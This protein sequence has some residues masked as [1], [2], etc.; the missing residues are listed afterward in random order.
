MRYPEMGAGLRPGVKFPPIEA[1]K[2]G[3]TNTLLQDT[4]IEGIQ[5][6]SIVRDGPAA[7][8]AFNLKIKM[9]DIPVPIK[10]KV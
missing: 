7:Y 8:L 6:L 10:I 5:D 1:I 9:I 4:R 3:L 2:D